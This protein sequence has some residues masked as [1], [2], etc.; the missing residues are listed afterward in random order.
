MTYTRHFCLVYVKRNLILII[1]EA[2]KLDKLLHNVRK[3]ILNIEIYDLHRRIFFLTK[4]QNFLTF[5]LENNLRPY[6]WK[7]INILHN[8]L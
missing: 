1:T 2:H 6:L 4:E 3:G 5:S 8:V 7:E